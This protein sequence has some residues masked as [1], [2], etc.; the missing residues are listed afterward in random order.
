[1]RYCIKFSAIVV[2]TTKDSLWYMARTRCKMWD[3]EYCAERNKDA[4]RKHIVKGI[5]K[6]GRLSTWWFITIT[7][8]RKAHKA[9]TQNA[10]L[11]NLQR[12]LTLLYGRLRHERKPKTPKLEYCRVFEKHKK[13]TIHAHF[14]LCGI[15]RSQ[16]GQFDKD[17]N[18]CGMLR[19]LKDNCA[20]IGLGYMVSIKPIRCEAG[21]TGKRVAGYVTKYMTKQS[22]S[23]LAFP[24]KVRR[25]QCSHAFGA[26][27]VVN[28]QYAFHIKSAIFPEELEQ[29]E[30]FDLNLNRKV[31]LSDCDKDGY[32][33]P[34]V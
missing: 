31:Q 6:I 9:K 17:G 32:Y 24:P 15:F 25:I 28:E 5:E 33:P 1:M 22:Q 8:H 26:L 19:W 10:T 27:K 23:F 29:R 3:C 21:Y 13:D 12:G 2:D 20:Q 34:E 4:W 18:D 16:N 30:V 14:I 11:K 7:A